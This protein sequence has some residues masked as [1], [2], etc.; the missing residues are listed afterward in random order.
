MTYNDE[1]NQRDR[2]TS[3]RNDVE[4][5]AS[6]ADNLPE[7]DF[8]KK[9]PEFE[10]K[11]SEIKASDTGSKS[12]ET[13]DDDV[14]VPDLVPTATA[15]R[16]QV[17][18]FRTQPLPHTAGRE[19]SVSGRDDQEDSYPSAGVTEAAKPEA[20]EVVEDA[21]KPEVLDRRERIVEA[22]I[23]K[24]DED[25]RK[26]RE[27]AHRRSGAGKDYCEYKDPEYLPAS[28]ENVLLR[29]LS[30]EKYN[31]QGELDRMPHR[32]KLDERQT[33]AARDLGYRIYPED[34]GTATIY[35]REIRPMIQFFQALEA[36]I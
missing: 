30:P 23:R 9:D 24:L 32:S 21:P 3:I 12:S 36:S 15:P 34:D 7:S 31:A 10:K 6:E 25:Y 28:A 22:V 2:A 11:D 5:Y 18:T 35:F 33:R 17:P 4:N 27:E 19:D 16:V 14:P 29:Y 8:E 1:W 20:V 26:S 13:A